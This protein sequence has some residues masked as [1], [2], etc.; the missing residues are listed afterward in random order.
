M[1]GMGTRGE[2]GFDHLG[3]CPTGFF[4]PAN[5]PRR[6]P[7]GIVLMG[8]GHVGDDGGVTSLLR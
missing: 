6:G 3:T 2:N 1:L 5:E 8:L 7:L 4:G